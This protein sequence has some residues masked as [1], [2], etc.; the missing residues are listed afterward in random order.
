MT[1]R[2]PVSGQFGAFMNALLVLLRAML[3]QP[4]EHEYVINS[5]VQ[6]APHILLRK[7]PAAR[8][9]DTATQ[10]LHG[11]IVEGRPYDGLGFFH[12]MF[13][14]GTLGTTRAYK[15]FADAR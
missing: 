12:Q 5:M 4:Q 6:D 3:T 1:W 15:V 11:A 8:A 9:G 7:T 10:F 2:Y 13:V 14:H